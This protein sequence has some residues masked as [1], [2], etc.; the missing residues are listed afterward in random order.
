MFKHL[1]FFRLKD[2]NKAENARKV[3]EML[4]GLKA[5]I[6]QIKQLETGINIKPGDAASDVSLYTAFDNEADFLIYRDHPSHLKVVEFIL[7]VCSERRYVDFE[8]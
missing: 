2:E 7:S 4:D 5:S 8:D 1:V 6:P 3:K